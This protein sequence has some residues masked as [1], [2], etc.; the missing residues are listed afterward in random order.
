[1][2][3]PCIRVVTVLAAELASCEKR[4]ETDT[5][6]VQHAAGLIGVNVAGDL[7]LVRLGDPGSSL[8]LA[9]IGAK[10]VPAP[11]K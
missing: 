11:L 6:A 4:D 9:L 8:R 1:M 7:F 10:C 2:T 5:G 3:W